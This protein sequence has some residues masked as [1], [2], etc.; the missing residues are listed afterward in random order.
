MTMKR[1]VLAPMMFFIWAP[2]MLMPQN[3]LADDGKDKGKGIISLSIVSGP[4]WVV[5][6]NPG[7]NCPADD[8]LLWTTIN[9]DDS[10]W[11]SPMLSKTNGGTTMNDVLPGTKALFMWY[12]PGTDNVAYF[13]YKFTLDAT[14]RTLPL[15][16]EA[17]VA[18][19][20]NY[21]LWV[22]GNFV[23]NGD[24][25]EHHQDVNWFPQIADLTPYLQAGTNVI[26]IRAN[27]GSCKIFDPETRLCSRV[28]FAPDGTYNAIEFNRG[29]KNL[30]FDGIIQTVQPQ[31]Q[32]N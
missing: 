26:A 9:Y 19:N 25:D 31:L 16:A 23:I 12:P 6:L 14:S 32:K 17:F 30:F 22:N 28:P 29:F 4:K 24:L 10:A 27:D 13:R 11:I 15:L 7:P 20:D 3:V 1:T 18:A 8:C 2:L 21:E 5:T